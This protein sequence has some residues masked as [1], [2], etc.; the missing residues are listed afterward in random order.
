MKKDPFS[1]RVFSV[2]RLAGYRFTSSESRTT[3]KGAASSAQSRPRENH[4]S[5]KIVNGSL[6]VQPFYTE[7]KTKQN[8]KTI[9]NCKIYKANRPLFWFKVVQRDAHLGK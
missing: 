2:V 6:A 3:R 4:N 7:P 8:K 5:A 1:A 9:T